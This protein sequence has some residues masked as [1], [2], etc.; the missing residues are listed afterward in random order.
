MRIPKEPRCP[1]RSSLLECCSSRHWQC[2]KCSPSHVGTRRA[3]ASCS[4]VDFATVI[5]LWNWQEWT[6]IL[7]GKPLKWNMSSNGQYQP[8]WLTNHNFHSNLQHCPHRWKCCNTFSLLAAPCERL[9][10]QGGCRSAANSETKHQRSLQELSAT[11]GKMSRQARQALE[12]PAA[13]GWW[14]W[15][16]CGSNMLKKMRR[17]W[18]ENHH[19]TYHLTLKYF[20][21]LRCLFHLLLQPFPVSFQDLVLGSW[22]YMRLQ[23]R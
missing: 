13:S 16:K 20:E 12:A 19:P 11:A 17:K 15:W 2:R 4:K 8:G 1:W 9:H 7:S 10:G 22:D 21:S 3:N 6:L 14:K 5:P 23:S 18:E